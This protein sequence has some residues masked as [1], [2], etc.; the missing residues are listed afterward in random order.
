MSTKNDKLEGQNRH[1]L[2]KAEQLKQRAARKLARSTPKTSTTPPPSQQTQYARDPKEHS[3]K[4]FYLFCALAI[5]LALSL[6]SGP[7]L[8]MQEIGKAAYTNDSEALL[9]TLD[10]SQ[11]RQH[12]I[13]RV[14]RSTSRKLDEEAISSRYDIDFFKNALTDSNAQ[15]DI[16]GP[17]L[18]YYIK[19]V[20]YSLESLN[21][22]KATILANTS[23]S[24][25]F[26]LKEKAS[27]GKLST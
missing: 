26:I 1:N 24:S 19:N 10:Q 12:I 22:V 8:A 21:Q 25:S 4:K 20:K 27:A 3:D 5:C 18:F 16:D 14:S 23:E 13:Q 15:Q 7:P 11:L 2:K 9:A 17:N 6:G